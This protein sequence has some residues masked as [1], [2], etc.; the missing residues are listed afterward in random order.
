MVPPGIEVDL[1]P[2]A[3]AFIKHEERTW[4]WRVP[5]PRGRRLVAKMYRHRGRM[6]ALRSR[7]FRFRVE[8]EHRRLTHLARHG[9][10]CTPPVGWRRGS[11]GTHGHFELLL[12]EE[13]PGVLQLRDHLLGGGGTDILPHLFRL[14]RRMHESGFCCQTLFATNVLVRSEG[15]A[16]G[17]CLIAD[18]PRSW[19][20]P[21]S[22]AGTGL[23]WY[24]MLD[25]SLDLV[26]LGIPWTDVPI[27]AYGLSGPGR[28]WWS[29]HGPA[30]G[31]AAIDS[32]AK[33]FRARRDAVA[34]LR[35]AAAW[36]CH[37]AF[38]WRAS[39]RTDAPAEDLRGRS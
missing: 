8:R 30:V 21:V 24:D 16:E 3:P 17:R 13:V 6:T 18:V 29:R 26:E 23:A 14:V 36:T 27:D 33:G 2:P 15:P 5:G 20:F 37:G 25:L 12:T 38:A 9:I 4:V 1:S 22:I 39:H 7:V 31:R 35:W 19:T 11:S 32:R 28:A 34:R 10:P